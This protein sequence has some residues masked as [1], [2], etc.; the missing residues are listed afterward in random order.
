[1]GLVEIKKNIFECIW[2]SHFWRLVTT[3][4]ENSGTWSLY[5]VVGNYWI[6]N[7][8]LAKMQKK[9]PKAFESFNFGLVT[10]KVQILGI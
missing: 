7:L 9:I 8:T 1:L 4:V 6:G 5:W 10:M 2:V 3:Q